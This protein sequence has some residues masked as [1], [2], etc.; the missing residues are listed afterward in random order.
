MTQRAYLRETAHRYKHLNVWRTDGTRVFQLAADTIKPPPPP[1][2]NKT[3]IG[4]IGDEMGAL[5]EHCGLQG[6]LA[7]FGAIVGIDPGIVYAAAAF[8]LPTDPAH[9][10]HQLAIRQ[11]YLYGRHKR[12]ARWLEDRK[13]RG[14][15]A[16]LEVG[17]SECSKRN[18]SLA[19]YIGWVRCWQKDDRLKVL[20]GFYNAAAIRHRS[21]DT[22]MSLRSSLDRACELIERLPGNPRNTAPQPAARR[23]QQ[24]HSV[25]TRPTLFVLGDGAFDT[26][27]KGK[28]PSRHRQLMAR[29]YQR[30]KERHPGSFLVGIDEYCSSQRCPRCLGRL[31]LLRR[32]PR[33]Q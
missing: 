7:H 8:S 3:I 27:M 4:E 21:W 2:K 13:I 1:L 30:V 29:L 6:P 28:Q 25:P 22:K 5:K 14:G 24:E 12:N 33:G 20:R 32:E 23:R 16:H 18:V 31:E 9:D 11:R 26:N 10:G 17:L 15:I 19:G